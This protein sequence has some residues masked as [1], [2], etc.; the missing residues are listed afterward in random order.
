[1]TSEWGKV[2]RPLMTI[3]RREA[4]EISEIASLSVVVELASEFYSQWQ[5]RQ[6][7]LQ[8]SEKRKIE[9]KQNHVL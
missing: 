3:M 7:I 1:M 8:Y 4:K 6:E 2:H 9:S 5:L